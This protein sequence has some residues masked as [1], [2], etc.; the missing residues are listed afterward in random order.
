MEAPTL[1]DEQAKAVQ[2]L[3]AAFAAFGE[4]FSNAHQ[5]GIDPQPYLQRMLLAMMG[6]QVSELSPMQRMVL[7][8]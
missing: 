5:A 3:A 4:A 2:D 6:D 7:G 1:N 8:L